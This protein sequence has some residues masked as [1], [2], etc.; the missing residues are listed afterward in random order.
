MVAGFASSLFPI[1]I[2]KELGGNH[3]LIERK[4]KKSGQK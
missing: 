2:I 4:E 3:N 1:F